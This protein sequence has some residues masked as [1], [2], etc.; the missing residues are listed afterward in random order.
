MSFLD[1]VSNDYRN[2][3][4]AEFSVPVTIKR[5]DNLIT[6]MG[7]FDNTFEVIDPQTQTRVLSTDARVTVWE[8][9]IPF[10]VRSCSVV[11]T[12]EGKD[13]K[14]RVWEPDNQGGITLYL[15]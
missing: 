12:V 15:D 1:G 10:S 6:L 2:M 9:D 8:A 3:L 5:D 7:L 14:L 4:T 13:Y 11:I